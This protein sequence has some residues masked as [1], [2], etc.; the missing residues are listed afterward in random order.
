[1]LNE[2]D[3]W[4]YSTVSKAFHWIVVSLLIVQFAVAWTM[5]HVSRATKPVGLVGWHLSIG[6]AIL[7][8]AL[9][10][11]AWRLRDPAPSAGTANAP[12]LRFLARATHVLLY[13]ILFALPIMGWANASYRGWT[14]WLFGWI[15]LPALVPAGSP[16]GGRMGDLH[17]SLATVFLAVIA[18]HVLGALYHGLVLRDGTLQRMLGRASR[19]R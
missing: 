19:G 17:A 10:R 2:R 9:A 1:M 16:L 11:L 6:T 7:A 4:E 15:R 5:P 8:V 12:Y 13:V 18:L 14:V 3:R